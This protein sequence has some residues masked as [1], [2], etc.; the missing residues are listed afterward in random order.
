MR[1]QAPKAPHLLRRQSRRLPCRVRRAHSPPSAT[2]LSEPQAL[3][4]KKDMVKFQLVYLVAFRP[5]ERFLQVYYLFFCDGNAMQVKDPVFAE[6]PF[7]GRLAT[8][9]KRIPPPH[10][11]AKLKLLLLTQE[12]VFANHTNP[13][14]YPSFSSDRL[15]DGQIIDII[16]PSGMGTLEAPLILCTMSPPSGEWKKNF[17]RPL[18][19][20]YSVQV[21]RDSAVHLNLYNN[22]ETGL[23]FV[24]KGAILYSNEDV[25]SAYY[26]PV[27]TSDGRVGRAYRP[28]PVLTKIH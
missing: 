11:V 22:V 5:T 20:Y 7:L 6:D 1:R 13:S 14:L 19:Y 8:L 23:S 3:F 24:N 25:A 17:P 28:T 2:S 27:V 4:R 10:S 9:P 18:G 16:S 26:C 12:G 15:R 21:L